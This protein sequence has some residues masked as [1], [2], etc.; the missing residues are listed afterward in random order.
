MILYFYKIISKISFRS[1]KITKDNNDQDKKNPTSFIRKW[2]KIQI[3]HSSDLLY[4]YHREVVLT[5]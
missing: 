4:K 2:Y 1:G 3:L 5:T